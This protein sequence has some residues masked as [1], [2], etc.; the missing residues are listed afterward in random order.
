[1]H[2]LFII[3]TE[4]LITKFLFKIIYQWFILLVVTNIYAS[5]ISL[6]NLTLKHFKNYLQK[7][8]SKKHSFKKFL[9]PMERNENLDKAVTRVCSKL[10]DS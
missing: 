7:R 10:K 3:C 1:M 9:K 4:I 5:K 8:P 6:T 2:D